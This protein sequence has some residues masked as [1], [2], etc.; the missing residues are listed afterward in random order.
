MKKFYLKNKLPEETHLGRGGRALAGRAPDIAEKLITHK[1]EV[2]QY[3]CIPPSIR[4]HPLDKYGIL[5]SSGGSAAAAA[6]GDDS[7][8][9]TDKTSR[10]II[11]QGEREAQVLDGVLD[12]EE[13]AELEDS[14]L[15]LPPEDDV[16]EAYTSVRWSDEDIDAALDSLPKHAV[17]RARRILPFL[18]QINLGD[19]DLGTV[20]YDLAVPRVKKLRTKNTGVLKTIYRQLE[21]I[22]TLPSN[23][24]QRKL[25]TEAD[26]RQADQRARRGTRYSAYHPD[27]AVAPGFE[28]AP[29]RARSPTTN[30][31]LD[32]ERQRYRRT[33]PTGNDPSANSFFY[34]NTEEGEE[35]DGERRAALAQE[36]LRAAESRERRS[37]TTPKS[38]P[39]WGLGRGASPRQTTSTPLLGLGRGAAAATSSFSSPS[40]A[41]AAQQRTGSFVAGKRMLSQ[42]QLHSAPGAIRPLFSPNASTI[43]DYV[44]P[45]K[46]NNSSI[47]SDRKKKQPLNWLE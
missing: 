4:P 23:L 33:A 32:S 35:D 30:L 46:N 27:T 22:R 25:R 5:D 36:M 17:A 13:D 16:G 21:A 18:E 43:S 14:S 15:T 39:L 3:R 31:I 37:L 29:L 26:E 45:L 40:G 1:T 42:S 28:N 12:T 38:P 7:L 11:K 8:F 10:K 44:T 47:K 6:R 9:E 41:I 34:G 2:A 19:A 24:I 20:L